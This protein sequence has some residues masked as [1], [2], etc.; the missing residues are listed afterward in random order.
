MR[1]ENSES[2]FNTLLS[3]VSLAA[4]TKKVPSHDIR[5]S[6]CSLGVLRENFLETYD[7][8]LLQFILQLKILL[9][10]GQR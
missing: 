8:G 7:V 4:H 10:G 2:Q 1:S 3:D 6:I 5:F 9:L